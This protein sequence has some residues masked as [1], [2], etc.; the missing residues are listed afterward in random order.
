MSINVR[1]SAIDEPK[2]TFDLWCRLSLHG[3]ILEIG[4]QC[5]T[6]FPRK[7]S[8][9]SL[10]IPEL[11]TALQGSSPRTRG[12]SSC[13]R[14]P[15]Q[16]GSRPW[17]QAQ[18]LREGVSRPADSRAG[19]NAQRKKS[20]KQHALVRTVKESSTVRTLKFLAPNHGRILFAFD[21]CLDFLGIHD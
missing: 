18:G 15:Q 10:D 16:A 13:L 11:R 9:R 8:L 4:C 5:D 12:Y 21:G 2:T 14:R 19:V 6:F 17:R 20:N 7:F 1:N 3:E